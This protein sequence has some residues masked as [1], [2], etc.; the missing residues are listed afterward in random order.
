MAS[1]TKG[2]DGNNIFSIEEYP[3]EDN[4]IGKSIYQFN[5]KTIEATG[6][7]F[8]GNFGP[9]WFSITSFKLIEEVNSE[10]EN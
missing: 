3:I 8:E 5:G 4:I 2:E 9:V 7:I 6:T 1:T 10:N